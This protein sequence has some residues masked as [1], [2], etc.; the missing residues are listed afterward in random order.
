MHSV[1]FSKEFSTVLPKVPRL[2]GPPGED[3]RE[4][5]RGPGTGRTERKPHTYTRIADLCRVPG[6]ATAPT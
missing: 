4:Q 5:S 1:I 2:Q 6:P 3:G